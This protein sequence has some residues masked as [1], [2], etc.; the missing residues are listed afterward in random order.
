MARQFAFHPAVCRHIAAVALFGIV[1]V[2][3]GVYRFEPGETICEGPAPAAGL[4]LTLVIEPPVGSGKVAT[5]D[6]N[7]CSMA[8]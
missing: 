5:R 1:A 6:R 3:S 7:S 2:S 4:A 8:R